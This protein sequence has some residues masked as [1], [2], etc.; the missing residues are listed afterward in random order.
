MVIII[1]AT[2]IIITVEW[3]ITCYYNY[4]VPLSLT[5]LHGVTV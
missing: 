5:R 1:I 4:F 3:F 2:V